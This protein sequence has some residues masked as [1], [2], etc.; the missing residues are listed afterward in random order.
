M[1]KNIHNIAIGTSSVAQKYTKK[2]KQRYNLRNKILYVL[3]NKCILTKTIG[4]TRTITCN[5]S[6][7]SPYIATIDT[8]KK[9]MVYIEILKETSRMI[10]SRFFLSKNVVFTIIFSRVLPTRKASTLPEKASSGSQHGSM[11]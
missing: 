5:L 3:K 10:A 1:F 8:A 6:G 7:I 11:G 9:R 4:K 2:C